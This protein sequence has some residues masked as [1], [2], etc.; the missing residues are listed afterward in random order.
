MN[1]GR[2]EQTDV[3]LPSWKEVLSTPPPRRVLDDEP[4]PADEP[5]VRD[6]VLVHVIWEVLLA[7]AAVGLVLANLSQAPAQHLTE[8]FGSAAVV[9]LL[10]VGLSFSLRTATPNLAVGVIAG[11]TGAL[12]AVLIRDDWPVPVAIAAGLGAALGTGVLLGLLVMLLS[13]PAWA[14]TL[15]AAAALLAVVSGLTRGA[16]V[17]A[18]LGT[19]PAVPA[20]VV[21]AGLSMGGGAVWLIPGV[22]RALGGLRREGE[23]AERPGLRAGLGALAG[24]AGSSLL[25]G[26]AGIADLLRQQGAVVPVEAVPVTALAA[27]LIGGVSV[28]GR[29]AGIFGTLFGVVIMVSAASLLALKDTPAWIVQAFAGGMVVAGL[30]VTRLI[31]GSNAVL[32][33]DRKR[34]RP[35]AAALDARKV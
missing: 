21:F 25:A 31:E 17:P 15:G 20:F 6:R 2:A 13:V 7:V 22:R 1:E 32:N 4:P 34:R 14:V 33:R 10:A 3:T 12:T 5:E 8:L 11:G 28:Y 18:D 29:R 23:P 35:R 24:L 9:G 27:V 26:V 30:L 16:T 19:Y